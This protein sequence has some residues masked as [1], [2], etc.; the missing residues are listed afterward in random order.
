MGLKP[1]VIK[2]KLEYMVSMVPKTGIEPVRPL[3]NTGF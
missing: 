3:L 1:I 2:V